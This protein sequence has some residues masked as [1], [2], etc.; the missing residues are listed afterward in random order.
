VGLKLRTDG[1][2]SVDQNL[3][4][5]SNLSVYP[6]PASEFITINS[7]YFQPINYKL[8]NLSSKL[9]KS[10]TVDKENEK[11]VITHL[12][13][14]VYILHVNGRNYKVLKIQ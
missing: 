2:L 11:I 8:F 7:E 9:V 4:N 10:G 3:N 5:K 12:P 1:S 6:N 13:E 14:G